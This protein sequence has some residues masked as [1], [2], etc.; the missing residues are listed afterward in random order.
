MPTI[1]FA[2][3]AGCALTALAEKATIVS[4]AANVKTALKRYVYAAADAQTVP[5]YARNAEKN[6]KPAPMIS[7]A[8][9]AVYAG[10]V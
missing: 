5:L 8:T 7:F 1:S 2:A 9:A 10:I 4:S 3:A 6:V